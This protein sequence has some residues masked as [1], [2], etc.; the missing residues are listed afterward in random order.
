M[1][2]FQRFKTM[3]DGKRE[4]YGWYGRYKDTEGR[5]QKVKLFKDKV[6]SQR[7]LNEIERDAELRSAGV[8]TVN[9]DHAKRPI[10]EHVA[11]YVASLRNDNLDADRLRISEW[12]MKKLVALGGW[13]K[14]ADI[15]VDSVEGFVNGLR[16]KGKPATASYRNKYIT[17]AKA[18]VRWLLDRGRLGTHTLAKLKK[19][20]EKRHKRVRARRALEDAERTALV[21]TAPAE[22]AWVYEFLMLTGLRRNE[23]AELR[24]D[25]LRL[26]APQ[27]FIQLR[28]EQIKSGDA[29]QVPLHSD[30]LAKLN[31]MIPGMPGAKVFKSIPDVAT[32]R[33]D[34]T[35]AKVAFID[36]HGLRA[37]IHA[38]R[39]TFCTMVCRSEPNMKKAQ[40]LTRHRD[41]RVLANI[42][43][44]MGLAD[45]S[46]SMA[47]VQMRQPVS[48]VAATGTDGKT[49]ANRGTL[50]GQGKFPAGHLAASAGTAAATGMLEKPLLGMTAIPLET[51]GFGTSGHTASLPDLKD[52]LVADNLAF[53]R[54]STQ[55]D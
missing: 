40:Q 10:S 23:A 48:A 39:H 37:D 45:T 2:L 43:A 52:L 49:T 9:M 13:K 38:M 11:D 17:R 25:D 41:L 5:W 1:P 32:L 46:E 35:A 51:Q 8:V 34:L 4:P 31:A 19:L 50:M 21:N 7:R 36:E 12:T 33:K 14:L 22:R 42:Y 20:D 44:H 26:N 6:S 16:V 24:W 27:P 15:T 3:P 29:E 47:K 54:P 55:V 30:L 28:P 18:F 53:P